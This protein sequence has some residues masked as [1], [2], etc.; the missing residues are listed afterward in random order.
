MNFPVSAI[1]IVVVV[2]ASGARCL[3]N[4]LLVLFLVVGGLM[5]TFASSSPTDRPTD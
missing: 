2:D 1:I 3:V 5:E 4:S